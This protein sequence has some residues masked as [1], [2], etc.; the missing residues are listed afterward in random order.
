MFMPLGERYHSVSEL[1]AKRRG[2]FDTRRQ[3]NTGFV[4]ILA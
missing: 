3:E 2:L 1:G 4:A